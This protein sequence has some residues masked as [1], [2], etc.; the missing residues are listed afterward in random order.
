[1]SLFMLAAYGFA[2]AAVYHLC[3]AKSA[4][5][6]CCWPATALRIQKPCG[7]AVHFGDDGHDVAGRAGDCPNRRRRKARLKA[8]EKER[9]KGDPRG[10]EAQTARGHAGGAAAELRV[11]G[12]AQIYGRRARL[13][14]R[15]AAGAAAAAGH[16]LFTRSNPWAIC[17][18]YTTAN[19]R[20]RRISRGS[21]C[22]F[23]FSRS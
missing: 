18:T 21:R 13:V 17:W 8:A 2:C 15:V 19:M 12:G 4:G 10:G 9:K 23:R 20:R 16:Q 11:A 7:A 1:M 6:F 3:P 5:L 14:R 22:S